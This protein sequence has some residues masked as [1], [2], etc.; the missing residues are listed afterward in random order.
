MPHPSTAGLKALHVSFQK[1]GSPSST[2]SS[3]LDVCAGIRTN[4]C[5]SVLPHPENEYRIRRRPAN[6]P[7]AIHGMGLWLLVVILRF[8]R[9][10]TAATWR[11]DASW[12]WTPSSDS[13]M[14]P[15]TCGEP[16]AD[17]AAESV[18]A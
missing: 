18:D 8:L 14:G 9:G 7:R 6:G 17:H 4:P 15:M 3:T 1:A 11:L 12:P 2:A 16:E 5:S 13:S 10:R